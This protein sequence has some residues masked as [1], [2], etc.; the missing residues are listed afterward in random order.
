MLIR[1]ASDIL[2]SEITDK[3]IFLNRRQ[4]LAAAAGLG[5]AM[6]LPSTAGAAALAAK[7]SSFSTSEPQTSKQDATGYNNFYE[8]G[9]D[10][11]DPAAYAGKLTTSPWTV[12]VDGLVDHPAD[13]Q[14]EDFTKPFALEE[15]IYRMRCVEGWSM[16]IPWDG[17]PLAEVLKRAGPQSAAKF[18][19]F[20]TLLRPDEMP[21]QTGF[22][23]PL[24]WPYVEGLRLDEAMHP[25]TILAIGAYGETLSNQQG[26]P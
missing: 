12:K 2:P 8:F 19:A 24:D 9:T 6:A 13:Y 4:L 18:V 7:P 3:D 20:E 22:F 26:A 17:F 11:A 1:H 15:R 10:K 16:V 23:Q 5:A 14:L 21:G 25:L